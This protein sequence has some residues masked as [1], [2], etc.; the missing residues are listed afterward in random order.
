MLE[1]DGFCRRIWKPSWEWGWKDFV[2][3]WKEKGLFIEM[4]V[5]WGLC[6]SV[7]S[8]NHLPSYLLI[9]FV[10]NFITAFSPRLLLHAFVVNRVQQNRA[11]IEKSNRTIKFQFGYVW[12]F[13]RNFG[14]FGFLFDRNKIGSVYEKLG[15]V[16]IE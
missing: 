9:M 7:L 10:H 5:L 11:E 2:L 4:M 8:P 16:K 14:Y 3:I 12:I 13:F 1:S 15:L 6:L